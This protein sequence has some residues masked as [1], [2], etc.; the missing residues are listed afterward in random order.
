MKRCSIHQT[1]HL[2]LEQPVCM[3]PVGILLYFLIAGLKASESVVFLSVQHTDGSVSPTR[4]LSFVFRDPVPQLSGMLPFA[5]CVGRGRK[6]AAYRQACCSS[7]RLSVCLP[8][9]RPPRSARILI[10]INALA[11]F[12]T[13]VMLAKI[14]SFVSTQPSLCILSCPS[15]SLASA[16]NFAQTFTRRPTCF[17]QH[18]EEAT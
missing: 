2:N 7:G 6:V 4:P 18:C 14:L 9:C 15:W 10:N 11:S 12:T 8:A 1:C 13:D 5:L 17:E 16:L 3:L